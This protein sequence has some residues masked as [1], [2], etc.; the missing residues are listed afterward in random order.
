WAVLNFADIFDLFRWSIRHSF[1]RIETTTID[2]RGCGLDTPQEMHLGHS[3]TRVFISVCVKL[4][5]KYTASRSYSCRSQFLAR[6]NRSAAGFSASTG[7]LINETDCAQGFTS[8][9][10]DPSTRSAWRLNSAWV[11]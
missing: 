8:T 10:S 11:V 1:C 3:T 5:V 7:I 9:T 4:L 6:T 2:H